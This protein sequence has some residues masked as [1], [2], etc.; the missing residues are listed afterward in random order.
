[1]QREVFLNPELLKNET[2]YEASLKKLQSIKNVI[3]VKNIKGEILKINPSKLPTALLERVAS[4]VELARN[5]QLSKELNNNSNALTSKVEGMS[6]KELTDLKIEKEFPN[7]TDYKQLQYLRNIKENEIEEKAKKAINNAKIKI[8]QIKANIRA[9][10]GLT[11]DNKLEAEKAISQLNLADETLLAE[12]FKLDL[13]AAVVSQG[14]FQS[15][16]FSSS[17]DTLTLGNQLLQNFR[18]SKNIKDEMIYNSYIAQV[19]IRDGEIKNDFIRYYVS[20]NKDV[21]VQSPEFSSKMIDIQRKMNI[22]EKDIKAKTNA[23]IIL[24]FNE[25]DSLEPTEA[26]TFLK[27][28]IDL[29]KE[30]NTA[31]YL[32]PQMMKNGFSEYENLTMINPLSSINLTFLRAKK[33]EETFITSKLDSLDVKAINQNVSLEF[34]NFRESAIG[35]SMYGSLLSENNRANGIDKIEMAI[36]KTARYIKAQNNKLSVDEATNQAMSIIN[37][38]YDIRAINDSAYRMPSQ[39][40]GPVDRERI[41]KQ[42]SNIAFDKKFLSGI[43]LVPENEE[44]ST[45]INQVSRHLNWVTNED[46]TGVYLINEGANGSQVINKDTGKRIEYTW[47]DLVSKATITEKT[48]AEI[49]SESLI[50]GGL[51]TENITG[52]SIREQTIA[53]ARKKQLLRDQAYKEMGKKK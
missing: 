10:G 14:H 40:I 33:V 15:I 48:D 50:G 21:D 31:Q 43:V 39:Q 1:M 45:Y 46:E 25:Y 9:G 20:Q 32:V 24:L 52:E 44:T 17:K 6:L 27:E 42:L 53:M 2:K 49:R 47:Q 8:I 16:K 12:S 23:D 34:S 26:A 35:K 36:A 51:D 37:E 18:D 28:T 30:N 41:H 22:K 13:N 38:N 19:G 11:A 3:I 4:R 7:V 5:E 29:A